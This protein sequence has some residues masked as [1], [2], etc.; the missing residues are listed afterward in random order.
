MNRLC[1]FTVVLIGATMMVNSSIASAQTTISANY[2]ACITEDLLDE[3]TDYLI[4][5]DHSGAGSLLLSGQCVILKPGDKVS[6]IKRGFVVSTIRYKGKK[7][8][9]PTEAIR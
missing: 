1:A 4:D 9:A 7:L 8:V 6:V 2:P 5:Q 3:F